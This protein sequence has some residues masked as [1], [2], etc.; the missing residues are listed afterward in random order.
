MRD[1]TSCFKGGL[2]NSFLC[3]SRSFSHLPPSQ[4]MLCPV[5]SPHRQLGRVLLLTQV[6]EER[7]ILCGKQSCLCAYMCLLSLMGARNER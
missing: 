4:P 1:V 2:K 3:G 5:N 6:S 7:W